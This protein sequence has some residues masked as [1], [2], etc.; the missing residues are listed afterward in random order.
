M[1]KLICILLISW[2]PILM[3]TANAMSLEMA[4]QA[5]SDEKAQ[6][7]MPCHDKTDQQAVKAHKC[8]DCG[9]CVIATSI[10]NANITSSLHIP[11]F[12]SF[13]LSFTND[14]LKSINHSPAYRPPILN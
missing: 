5:M 11:E 13:K 10:V 12:K 3:V 4:T 2:L 6:A 8:I 14:E 7:S 1:K 9:F